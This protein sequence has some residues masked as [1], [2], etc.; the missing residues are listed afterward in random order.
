MFLFSANTLK[1]MLQQLDGQINAKESFLYDQ[2]NKLSEKDKVISNQRSE[3]ERLEKKSKTLE[4]KVQ[5][6]FTPP[7]P[8]PFS[9]IF[10]FFLYQHFFISLARSTSCRRRQTCTSRTNDPFSRSWRRGSSSCRGSC[11][12]GGAWSSACRA[13]CRTP[14]TSGRRSV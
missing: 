7:T 5:F 13:W 3:L 10:F 2:R 12:R 8:P 4:Y 1:S 6:R 9:V 14:N 11:R